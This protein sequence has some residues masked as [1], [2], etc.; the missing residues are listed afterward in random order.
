M[1]V[2]VVM[3]SRYI[4]SLT[5]DFGKEVNIDMDILSKLLGSDSSRQYD[6]AQMGGGNLIRLVIG[7][8]VAVIVTVGVA[9]PITNDVIA[10]AN[11]TGLT[12]TVVGFIPVML[13]VL[14]FV[15]TVAPIMNRA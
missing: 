14:I 15:A 11:L 10:S 2:F 5:F 3:V 9:I 4:A 1:S 12:A 8:A 6:R 7:I 13:G